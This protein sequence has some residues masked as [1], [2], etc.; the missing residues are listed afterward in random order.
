MLVGWYAF[1]FVLVHF[2]DLLLAILGIDEHALDLAPGSS[3]L[4]AAGKCRP[5]SLLLL[6][7]LWHSSR[8][9][10]RRRGRRRG[11]AELEHSESTYFLG[12]PT[13]VIA[14]PQLQRHLVHVERQDRWIALVRRIDEAP[15]ALEQVRP[16]RQGLGVD[17]GLAA[18][19]HTVA[20]ER[21]KATTEQL[22][23]DRDQQVLV[24]FERRR[25]QQHQLI[26]RVEPL[27]EDGRSL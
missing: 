15:P 10:R 9:R 26:D 2:D 17:L 6:A 25:V 1:N 3:G 11:T 22:L 8:R 4:E 13:K 5:S 12:L 27:E 24:P 16:Q 21:A 23:A 18:L 19:R 20:Q 7:L 14:R